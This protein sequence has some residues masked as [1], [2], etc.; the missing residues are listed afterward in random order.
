MNK[1][2]QPCV[3]AIVINDKKEILFTKRS[4]DDDFLPGFW[5]IPGGGIE[6]GETAQEGLKRELKEECGIDIEVIKPVGVNSYI[7]HE[8]QRIEI[9]FLSKAKNT[10]V[11]LDHEHSEFKWL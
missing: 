10:D 1:L 7:M 5:D 11:K 8:I 4:M 2:Q 9:T 3:S 6:Y